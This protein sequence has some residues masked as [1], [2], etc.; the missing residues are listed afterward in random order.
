MLAKMN[1]TPLCVGGND[2]IPHDAVYNLGV[3]LDSKPTM[4]NQVNGV[5]G[6]C[7]NQLR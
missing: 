6:S 1:E 3:I 7:F 5:K 2:V 4:K